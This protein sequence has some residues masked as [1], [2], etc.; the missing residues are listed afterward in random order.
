[1]DYIIKKT[2]S[3]NGQFTIKPYSTNGPASPS[4]AIPLDSHAVTANTS[5][6]LLGKGMYEYGEI[7]ASD[8]VHLLE[9]FANSTPPVYPIQGQLWYKNNTKEL[10]VY[11][12]GNFTTQSIVINGLLTTNLN[13]NAHRV[14][15]VADPVD[16]T[17]AVTLQYL[18]TTYVVKA[19]DTMDLNANLTFNGGEVL[20]L[21]ATPSVNDAATSKLYVDTQIANVTSSSGTLYVKLAGDTMNLNANLAFDGGEVVGLPS[22]PTTPGSAAS[23]AYVDAQ[24]S[25]SGTFVRKSGDTMTGTLVI[26]GQALYAGAT[27]TISN[28]DIGI[29][30]ITLSGGD[31]TASFILGVHFEAIFDPTAG[32]Q[33]V[34]VGG[35]KLGTDPTGLAN[36]AT[37]YTAT[38]TVD[39]V[40][41]SVSII[42]SAAQTYTD[43]LTEINTDLGAAA[44]A[45]LS[46][47]NI[48]VTSATTSSSSSVDIVDV[49]LFGTLT[50][51]VAILTAVPGTNSSVE[52]LTTSNSI[53]NVGPNTTTVV[54][55]ETLTTPATTGTVT[56]I[57]GIWTQSGA[58]TLLNGNLIISGAHTVDVGNN[59]VVNVGTPTNPADAATKQYVDSIVLSGGADGTLV[60]GSFNQ[61]TNTLTLVSS[62]GPNVDIT[63]MVGTSHNH[64]DDAIFHNTSAPNI[65]DSRFRTTLVTNL[66]YP[67]NSLADTLDIIDSDLY[68]LRH[69][70]QRLMITAATIVVNAVS[71]SLTG[72]ILITS[73][74]TGLNG[75]IVVAG[76]YTTTFIPN[77]S[78]IVSGNTDPNMNTSWMVLSSVFGGGNT[79]IT[80]TGTIPVTAANDGQI[81]Q[82]YGALRVAGTVTQDISTGSRINLSGNSGTGN[83]NYYIDSVDATGGNTFMYMSSTTPLP[84]GTT[85][86]GAIQQYTYIM[87]FN[88][89]VQGH[90]LMVHDNGV[91]Q[92][93][94]SRG[95]STF[96]FGSSINE[97]TDTGLV[98]G[99]Y[100]FN[101]AV[102]GGG[103]TLIPIT[104]AQTTYTITGVDTVNNTWTVSGSWTSDFPRNSK[105]NVSGNTGTGDGLYNVISAVGSGADTVITVAESINGGATSDG[106]IQHPYTYGLLVQDINTQFGTLISGAAIMF[107][108]DSTII[109][110]SIASGATSQ[111]VITD[112]SLFA[113]LSSVPQIQN[114]PVGVT[115]SYA[116]IGIP[117]N[118]GTLVEFATLP[119]IG[120]VLEFIN[121]R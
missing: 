61:L 101:I 45:S 7:I 8:F 2:D 69:R 17:D 31:Y 90:K 76:D 34:D 88:Y 70:N 50:G 95:K 59:K 56:A 14:V 23:K 98:N 112:V 108:E 117:S 15:N 86:D 25:G 115:Y 64:E 65:Q 27:L 16:P 48:L 75:T 28:V 83:G 11:D 80:V 77:V 89:Q 49:D 53:Y 96:V 52:L 18:G 3:A 19:G 94:H 29:S 44:T 73:V 41:I 120:N 121:T 78:F 9:N 97:E 85:G 12:S 22:V 113:A 72:N 20:G 33:I 68:Y 6:I 107:I 32:H 102:N 5:L 114:S 42:G 1:M 111:I 116:E 119:T 100:Q 62:V 54:V 110:Y 84:V 99:V 4:A 46:N 38:I 93:T 39:T 60:S 30:E 103:N 67:H 26:D 51:Y 58:E 109:V 55:S 91:K 21:P 104:V 24:V 87:P 36:D 57:P 47:G 118:T 105:I 10:F 82:S 40:P 74:T 81:N 66:F 92:Y 13:V 106:T 43:L 35:T 79:T 63:G 37:V 71:T